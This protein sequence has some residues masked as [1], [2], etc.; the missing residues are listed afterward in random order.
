MFDQQNIVYFNGELMPENQVGISIRDRGFIYGDAVFDATRTFGG[1]TFK[2]H[3]HVGRLY[4]SLRYLRI[5]PGLDRAEMERW[6]LAV[7]NHNYPLL[8]RGQDLWVSQRITRGEESSEL[9]AVMRPT[10]LIETRPIPFAKRASLYRD[11]IKVG[12]P[13]VLRVPPR[14]FSPRAKTHNYL[15]LI[16]G[17]LEVQEI[18]PEAWAVLLDEDGNLTEGKGSNIFLVKDGQVCTPQGRFVLGGITR[19]VVLELAGGLG[20]PVAERDLDLFDAY[21]ADEAFL[22]STSLCICPISAVN[23][24]TIG[25]GAIPGPVTKQLMAAFSDLARMDYVAQY[26]SHLPGMR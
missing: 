18:D 24:N 4:D 12:T 3:E 13:S 8:P 17:E 26:L 7:A 6:S 20:M 2:L 10:V 15:N 16:M 23:G 14:F 5:D 25:T 1:Q 11:G 9:G 22:T 19:N 21:V